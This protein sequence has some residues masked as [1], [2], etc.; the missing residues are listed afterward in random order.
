MSTPGATPLFIDTD[1]FL[2]G[3][4]KT[5]HATSV[6]ERFLTAFNAVNSSIARCIRQGT[7]SLN[8]RHLCCVNPRML[9]R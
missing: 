8:W 4:L 9:T 1:A 5:L 3:S 2:R 7:F 6:L